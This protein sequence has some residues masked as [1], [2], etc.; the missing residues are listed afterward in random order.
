MSYSQQSR[1]VLFCRSAPEGR[2]RVNTSAAGS[3][4]LLMPK[5]D[6]TGL[7]PKN[8]RTPLEAE[9]SEGF[10]IPLH[11]LVKLRSG[12]LGLLKREDAGLLLPGFPI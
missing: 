5:A 1:N 7:A 4:P 3:R 8:R 12:G 11:S 10:C 2:V 6:A 9:P